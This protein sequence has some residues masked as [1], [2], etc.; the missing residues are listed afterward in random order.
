MHNKTPYTSIRA[1]L[2]HGSA[3]LRAHA[4]PTA[5]LDVECLLQHILQLSKEQLY[6]HCERS[7]NNSE[8]QQL[9]T[10]LQRRQQGEPIAY[11]TGYKE[12]YGRNF[13]VDRRVL[14]PRPETE[15]LITLAKDLLAPHAALQMLDIGTGSGC[16]AITLAL[17]FQHS[18]VTAWDIDR[19]ALAVAQDNAHRLEC[20][21]VSFVEHDIFTALPASAV[22]FDLI[23]ANPPYIAVT[24]KATLPTAVRDYEPHTAL[25]AA[26]YGLACYRRIAQLAPLLLHKLGLLIIELNPSTAAAVEAL[27][28]EQGLQPLQREYDLHGLVRVL[29]L[30]EAAR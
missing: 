12:F 19:D 26:E 7:L 28:T 24:E 22:R 15:L 27:L 3:L 2:R 23:V 4:S 5:V 17:E 18:Q 21:N 1:A 11:L 20:N 6:A 29:V 10:L 16:L 8:Q 13:G 30:G 14:I 25:F 9:H